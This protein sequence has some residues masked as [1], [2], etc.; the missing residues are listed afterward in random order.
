MKYI[1]WGILM[2][3]AIIVV[4]VIAK[5]S[6]LCFGVSIGVWALGCWI[7]VAQIKGGGKDDTT[8]LPYVVQVLGVAV[9]M[10]WQGFFS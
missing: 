9:M 7:E 8:L 2:L 10:I 5:A 6:A 4:G 3:A 1:G